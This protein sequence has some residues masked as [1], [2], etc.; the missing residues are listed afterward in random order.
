MPAEP[1]NALL[2]S[3]AAPYEPKT[4]VTAV[5]NQDSAIRAAVTVKS[6]ALD[7]VTSAMSLLMAPLGAQSKVVDRAAAVPA[8]RPAIVSWT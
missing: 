3:S 4:T 6:P 2:R 7:D 1:E 8:A 5:V